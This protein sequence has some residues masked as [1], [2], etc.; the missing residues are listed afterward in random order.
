MHRNLTALMLSALLLGCLGTSASAQQDPSTAATVQDGPQQRFA[1]AGRGRYD[2]DEEDDERW[3]RRRQDPRG[4]NRGSRGASDSD[5]YDRSDERYRGD[6]DQQRRGF[7]SAARGEF[8]AGHS[9][10]MRMMMILMDTDG[11]GAV[12]LQEFQAGQERIFKAMDADKDG[13]L[14]LEEIRNFHR[15]QSSGRAP[16]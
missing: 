12:S 13:R 11:D 5:R 3:D 6:R 10:M 4:W 16:Q 15:G 9:G 14:T 1:Q 8:A 2:A 7:P